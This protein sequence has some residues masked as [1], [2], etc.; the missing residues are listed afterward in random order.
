MLDRQRRLAQGSAQPA[1]RGSLAQRELLDALGPQL[2]EHTTA[3]RRSAANHGSLA[4]R[5][6]LDALGPQLREHTGATSRSARDRAARDRASAILEIGRGNGIS[7]SSGA[8][9]WID[10]ICA[11]AMP[12]FS[13]S[14]VQTVLIHPFSQTHPEECAICLAKLVAGTEGAKLPCGETHI[15]HRDCLMEWLQRN[16]SCPLC[17]SAPPKPTVEERIAEME[18]GDLEL[19]RELE[20]LDHQMQR[21]MELELARLR[22]RHS[23]DDNGDDQRQAPSQFLA[24]LDDF[25]R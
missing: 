4:Q 24:E 11:S 23:D 20:D 3:T 12:Q 18:R 7:A 21:E 15:F 10:E 19:Q 13:R 8:Q 16:P 1:A 5:E 14:M 25:D 22:S 2:R 9:R 17:R 6:L